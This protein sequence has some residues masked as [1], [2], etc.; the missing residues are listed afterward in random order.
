MST[1]RPREGLERSDPGHREW[2]APTTTI[3]LKRE[4][5]Q[6][7]YNPSVRKKIAKQNGSTRRARL[8]GVK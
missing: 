4:D 2:R 6:D 7:H 3:A 1:A 5:L 8:Q